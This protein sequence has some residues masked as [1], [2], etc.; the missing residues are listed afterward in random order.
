MVRWGYR[1]ICPDQC[2]AG[3]RPHHF[4]GLWFDEICRLQDRAI[5]S[6]QL[7]SK[8]FDHNADSS[9]PRYSSAQCLPGCETTPVTVTNGVAAEAVRLTDANNSAEVNPVIFF[10]AAY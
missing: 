6:R 3:Y 8:V 7:P 1:L 10:I 9:A 2:Q 5:S 4:A